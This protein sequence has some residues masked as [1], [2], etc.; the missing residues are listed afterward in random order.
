[1]IDLSVTLV[2]DSGQ[3][4]AA[5]RPLVDTV[6]E[7]VAGGV[8]AVQLREKH[9]D[10]RRSLEL[11]DALSQ[12]LPERIPI[13]VN[14]RVDVFLAAR[15]RGIRIAGI[16]IGQ[17]DLPLETARTLVGPEAV[18]GLTTSS[19]EEVDRAA[20]SAARADYLGIGTVRETRS[21]ADAPPPLGIPGVAALAERAA[22]SGI[23]AVAIG[24]IV[25]DD[26]PLLRE[27]GL[28]GAAVVSWVCAAQDPRAAAAALAAAWRAPAPNTHPWKGT[29]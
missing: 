16:H 7:A 23:P 6:A 5:G 9:G 1:M 21:K 12:R 25:A 4:E 20:A 13:L 8:T 11:L 18:I 24:G 22:R 27:R 29:K 10:A 26:L 15:L 2:T 17:D 19:A 14:D 3:S 28:A